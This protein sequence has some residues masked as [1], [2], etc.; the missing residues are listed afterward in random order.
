ML[1]V[2]E[3]SWDFWFIVLDFV[4]SIAVLSSMDGMELTDGAVGKLEFA[5][6]VIS[7]ESR[8]S[9]EHSRRDRATGNTAF[10]ATPESQ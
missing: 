3:P 7:T 4:V 2:E 9:C 10:D 8:I 5:P 6:M 1:L